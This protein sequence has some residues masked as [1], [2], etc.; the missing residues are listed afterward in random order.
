[1]PRDSKTLLVIWFAELAYRQIS[2]SVGHGK[3]YIREE[4][5]LS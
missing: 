4:T 2:F 1:M 5:Q 3:T